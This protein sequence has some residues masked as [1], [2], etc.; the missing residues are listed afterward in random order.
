MVPSPLRGFYAVVVHRR[1]FAAAPL[2]ACGLSPLRF[3]VLLLF[4]AGVSLSLHRLP[5]VFHSLRGFCE[6]ALVVTSM[7]INSCRGVE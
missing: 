2:P 1:G 6:K 7:R 5:V 3:F 4:I